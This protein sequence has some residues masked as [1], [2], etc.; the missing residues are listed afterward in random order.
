M[1]T[2]RD[3]LSAIDGSVFRTITSQDWADALR[4]GRAASSNSV[5]E[6]IRRARE[7]FLASKLGKSA[8]EPSGK[9]Q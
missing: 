5:S 2:R 6:Q 4:R 8:T 7:I 3:I 1:N 9:S